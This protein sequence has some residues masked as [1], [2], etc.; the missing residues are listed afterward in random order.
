MRSDAR[1]KLHPEPLAHY[2]PTICGLLDAARDAGRIEGWHARGQ[3]LEAEAR[4]DGRD[5]AVMYE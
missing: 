2:D 5:A 1:K 4:E 3:A